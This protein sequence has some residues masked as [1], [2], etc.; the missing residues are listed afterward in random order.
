MRYFVKV[1]VQTNI[2]AS[3]PLHDQSAVICQSELIDTFGV[4]ASEDDQNVAVTVCLP[5]VASEATGSLLTVVGVSWHEASN[6]LLYKAKSLLSSNV[7]APN[8][9][10]C[11]AGVSVTES[12][13]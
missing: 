10:A 11:L 2:E 9:N 6:E 13:G 8:A 7:K 1:T 3:A 4:S 5:A 12:T